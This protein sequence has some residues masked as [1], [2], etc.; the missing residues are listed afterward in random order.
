MSRTPLH[1]KELKTNLRSTNPSLLQ[2]PAL[3]ILVSRTEIGCAVPYA[4]THTEQAKEIP[5]FSWSKTEKT[6][7]D[8]Q[9]RSCPPE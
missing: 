3:L 7:K 6:N 5:H 9:T 2:A 4:F 1:Y 8:E